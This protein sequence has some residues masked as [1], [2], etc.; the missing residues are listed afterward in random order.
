MGRLFC[1]VSFYVLL[2]FFAPADF[3]RSADAMRVHSL[4]S[5]FMFAD[6]QQA[7]QIFFNEQYI[8]RMD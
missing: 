3:R 5:D 2:C 1:G 4:A 8:Y 6:V 7:G